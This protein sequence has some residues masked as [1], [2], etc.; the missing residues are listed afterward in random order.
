[1]TT[2][3]QLEKEFERKVKELQDKICP[4]KKTKWMEQWWAIG[5]STGYSVKVCLRCN[6]IV[7]KKAHKVVD[8]IDD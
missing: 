1:M 3:K 6:K 8:E 2:Y 7:D 5:H 4:H